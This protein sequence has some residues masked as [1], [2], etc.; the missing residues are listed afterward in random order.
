[1]PWPSGLGGRGC[2]RQL[3]RTG[4]R[5]SRRLPAQ[6]GL[7][8]GSWCFV[9][10]TVGLETT[11]RYQ[12]H[13]APSPALIQAYSLAVKTRKK[14]CFREGELSL[15]QTCQCW[16]LQKQWEV[17]HSDLF[18]MCALAIWGHF[19]VGR[20]LCWLCCIWTSGF[21][22]FFF[23]FLILLHALESWG[24]FQCACCKP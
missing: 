2:Q 4:L 11:L 24:T 10:S 19:Q 3:G 14:W 5:G 23:L 22:G 21:F 12:P 1:M 9:V 20:A 18:C 13:T 8:A 6:T 17:W 16:R 15:A 7:S